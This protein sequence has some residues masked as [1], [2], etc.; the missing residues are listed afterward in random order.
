MT[1]ASLGG[2]ANETRLARWRALAQVSW[3]QR[4]AQSAS[5]DALTRKSAP[6]ARYTLAK[7]TIA[8]IPIVLIF[9]FIFVFIQ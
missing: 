2:A 4:R 5:E 7:V 8:I 6:R 9:F 1:R 3:P